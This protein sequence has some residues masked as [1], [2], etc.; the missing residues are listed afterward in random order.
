LAII[1]VMLFGFMPPAQADN[2]S[3]IA[4][5]LRGDKLY[6]STDVPNALSASDQ[7]AVRT[8][9]NNAKDTDIR[10]V[11]TKSTQNGV[12]KRQLLQM[13][14]AVQQ[15][16]GKGDIYLAVTADD[17][18]TGLAKNSVLSGNELNQLISQASGSDIKSRLITFADLADTKAKD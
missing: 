5:G 18:M 11:V 8:A 4:N 2:V 12:T 14:K 17:K 1:G 3:Q 6:V 16:V 7:A 10:V 9:L 13:L 15:R